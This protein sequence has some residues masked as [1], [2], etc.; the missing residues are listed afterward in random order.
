MEIPIQTIY[1]QTILTQGKVISV[2]K[3]KGSAA[4][5]EKHKCKLCG[6][7]DAKHRSNDCLDGIVFYHQTDKIAGLIIKSNEM[8]NKRTT[9]FVGGGIYFATS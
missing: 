7:E 1:Q 8:R 9:D 5:Y 6:K 3:Q 2:V 4:F